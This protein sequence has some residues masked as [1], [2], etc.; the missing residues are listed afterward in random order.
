MGSKQNA[1]LALFLL[2]TLLACNTSSN[3]QHEAEDSKAEHTIESKIEDTASVPLS[4]R[5]LEVQNDFPDASLRLT[6]SETKGLKQGPH[7]FDFQ[8]GNFDLGAASPMREGLQLANSEKGQHIHF[9]VNN[10]PYSA[11]Y[12]P[13]FQKELLEGN[14]VVLA[15]LSRSY[16]ESVKNKEAYVLQNFYVGEEGAATFD[17]EAP[18]LFYS[19]PKGVYKGDGGRKVLLDFYLVNTT[20]SAEGNKVLVWIDG[21]EFVITSWKAHLIEGLKPG[22]HRV[23]IRLVDQD[24]A[25]VEGPFNDSGERVFEIVE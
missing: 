17:A 24:G 10:G 23:R 19:R 2:G 14:N 15:F 21:Q 25:L 22:K 20:I 6:S 11:H 5:P 1:V 8:V 13:S 7:S 16:H 18:Q 12:E 3:K 4:I 9:I